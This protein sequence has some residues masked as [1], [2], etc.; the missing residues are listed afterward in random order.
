VGDFN[1][2]GKDDLLA[3]SGNYVGLLAHDGTGFTAN[4][5]QNT[6]L[7]AWRYSETDKMDVGDF[8]NDGKD[9]LLARSGNYVGLLTHNGTSFTSNSIQN[10]WLGAWRYSETDKMNVGD[11]NGDG[12]DDLFARSGGNYVGLL[13]HDGTGFTSLSIQNTWLGAWRYSETDKMNVGDFN[14]DGKDDLLVRQDSYVGLLT[15]NG[16]GF[17]SNSIQNTW[18]GGWRYSETDKIDV[19][20]FNNDGKDDLLVHNGTYV[21][22]LTYDEGVGFTPETIQNTW[23]GGWR[24]SALDEV[25]VADI[26]I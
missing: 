5:I 15:H 18:L 23:L 12:K 7:G 19:G 9:D 10:T 20:D 24:A 17:T 26:V 25:L 1:N 2:D 13:T 8:N 4:S 21:G 22:L 16:I 3:R 14:N 11:F 6:W